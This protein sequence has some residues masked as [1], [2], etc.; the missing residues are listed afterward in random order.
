[1]LSVLPY[2]ETSPHGFIW[3]IWNYSHQTFFYSSLLLLHCWLWN[4]TLRSYTTE[5]DRFVVLAYF[6]VLCAQVHPHIAHFKDRLVLIG[7]ILFLEVPWQRVGLPHAQ[8]SGPVSLGRVY[9]GTMLGER[10]Q[11]SCWLFSRKL[12]QKWAQAPLL[13]CLRWS[14][15]LILPATKS[16]L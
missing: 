9:P 15:A 6:A 3:Q 5:W 2:C 14:L 13:W 8:P 10:Q 4:L 1:M 7:H 16:H 11:T 12:T